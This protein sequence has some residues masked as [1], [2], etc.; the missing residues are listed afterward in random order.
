[1]H[2]VVG[3]AVADDRAPAGAPARA[4][5][6]A[7]ARPGGVRAPGAGLV[8]DRARLDARRIRE[9]VAVEEDLVVDRQ[10]ERRGAGGA[11]GRAAGVDAAA[12]EALQQ[13]AGAGHQIAA[14][15]APDSGREVQPGRVDAAAGPRGRRGA[16]RRGGGR[17]AELA[18]YVR[19][20]VVDLRLDG[21]LVDGG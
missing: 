6:I 9:Q 1:G 8:A 19:S 2:P 15:S 5:R 4:V 12:G 16:G 3:T 21:A 17:R 20:E 18:V 7:V 10:A 14:V 13:A 11:V